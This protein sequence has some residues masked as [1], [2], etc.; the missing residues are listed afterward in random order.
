[1]SRPSTGTVAWRRHPKKPGTYCWQARYTRADKTRTSW[2]LLDPSIPEHDEA[3]ARK[4]A[5]TFAPA[6]KASTKDGV[7]ELVAAYSIRWLAERR[8]RLVSVKDDTSRLRDHVLPLVGHLSVLS[9]TRD[10]VEGVRDALDDKVA[11]GVIS[12]KTARC[13]WGVFKTMCADMANARRRE[14]RVRD[15]DVAAGIK[16]TLRGLRKSK[17]YLYP[18]EFLAFLACA[19]VP[20][21]WRVA[22]ALAIFTYGRDG[23]VAMLDWS[24][25]DLEHGVI[26][27]DRARNRDTGEA[28]STKSGGTRRFSI[29]PNL[30]PMLRA[31]HAAAEGKGKVFG[32][33]ATHLSRTFRRWLLVAGVTRAELHETTETSR[34]ITWHDLRA[35]GAT[36]MAVRGDKP[37]TIQQR[38]GHQTF[39]TTEMYLREAEILTEGF[40]QPFPAFRHPFD[41]D[42]SAP[43]IR[44]KTSLLGAGHEVRTRDLRLGK[45]TLYQLS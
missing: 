35:T 42:V 41:S 19:E 4:L 29:E 8:T 32:L 34:A 9:L 30:L 38:C 15:S 27:I 20:R 26:T 10:D 21:E 25:I 14:L 1:M 40:G 23:E 11:Q 24:K 33:D 22:V 17:Q 2:C 13:A 31:M 37:L 28:K 43:T 18:S 44:P 6:A 12:W 45:P 16:P 36:W 3:A 5:L 7:G 39:S